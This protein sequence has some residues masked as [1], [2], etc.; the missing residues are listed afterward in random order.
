M[1]TGRRVP[2]S[3]SPAGT[4]AGEGNDG[5]NRLRYGLKNTLSSALSRRMGFWSALNVDLT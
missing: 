4:P 3:P 5:W 1:E 2:S